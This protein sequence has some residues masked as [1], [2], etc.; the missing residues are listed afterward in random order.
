MHKDMSQILFDQETIEQRVSQLAVDISKDYEHKHPI[1]I[2]ILKGSFM[3]LSELVKR[4]TIPVQIDFMAISS[5][6]AGAAS[7][8][9]IKIRKEIDAEIKDRDIIIIEDIVD[10]GISMNSLVKHLKMK[11]PATVKICTLLNKPAA[12]KIEVKIDY[13]GFDV[14][15]KFIVGYGLDYAE[16]YRQLPY[17]AILKEEIYR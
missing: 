17:I 12:R 3:F 6:G 4:L 13:K 16:N 10:T 2:G 14:E 1:I 5:Y 7:S 15:D 8:G 11:E 9:S